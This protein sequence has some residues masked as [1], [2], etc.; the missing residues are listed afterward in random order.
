[1]KPVGLVHFIVWIVLVFTSYH[2]ASNIHSLYNVG[3]IRQGYSV[4]VKAHRNVLLAMV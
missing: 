3:F 4:K 1:M 2:D